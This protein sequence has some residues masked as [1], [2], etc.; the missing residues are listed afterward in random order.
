MGNLYVAPLT[1]VFLIIKN[2]VVLTSMV[3]IFS[4]RISNFYNINDNHEMLFLI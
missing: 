3:T 4:P 1:P 2:D